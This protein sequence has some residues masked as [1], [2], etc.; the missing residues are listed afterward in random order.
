ML[1]GNILQCYCCIECLL[2]LT[3]LEK[4]IICFL[5][6]CRGMEKSSPLCQV[7]LYDNDLEWLR[8]QGGQAGY[9]SW[10]AWMHKLSLSH[11]EI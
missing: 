9:C 7:A 1:C 5:S 4:V 2:F 6:G 3:G 11:G 8:E 10:P